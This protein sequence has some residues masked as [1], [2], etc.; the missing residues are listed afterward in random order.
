MKKSLNNKSLSLLSTA[1]WR[2][3]EKSIYK[4]KQMRSKNWEVKN[5]E[6]NSNN[7]LQKN[8]YRYDTA[9]FFNCK[10]ERMCTNS[11]SSPS[12]LGGVPAC[13]VGRAESRGGK[14][15]KII[16]RQTTPSLRGTPP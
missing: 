2:V 12:I 4:R 13:P 10:S 16:F 14:W 15:K 11:E 6:S 3:F 9:S 5:E 7:N 8:K 1:T